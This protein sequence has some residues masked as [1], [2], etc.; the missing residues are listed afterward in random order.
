MSNPAIS[1]PTPWLLALVS[2]K[3]TCPTVPASREWDT[4]TPEQLPRVPDG[5]RNDTLVRQVGRWFR[6]GLDLHEIFFLAVAWNQASCDPPLGHDVIL[7]TV[8]SI[9]QREESGQPA[10]LKCLDLVSFLTLVLPL[11]EF[12]IGLILPR[13]GLVMIHAPA[14]SCVQL[15]RYGP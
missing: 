6:K 2:G 3:K 9:R 4:G 14:Q 7:R 15:P 11:R 10:P 5:V 8:E 13:Q 1:D 12:I